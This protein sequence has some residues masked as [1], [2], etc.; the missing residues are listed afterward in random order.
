MER[1]EEKIVRIEKIAE[2]EILKQ[3]FDSKKQE[4]DELSDKLMRLNAEFDNY[5]KRVANEK[6]DLMDYA[7]KDI[8]RALLPIVD[9]FEKAMDQRNGDKDEFYNGIK[10]IFASLM[11]MLKKNGLK[12]MDAAGSAFDPHFHEAIAVVEKSDVEENI[13]IEETHAGYLL[14]DKVLRPAMVVISKKK[15]DNKL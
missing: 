6:K 4:V 8:L 14:H 15:L 12:K 10:M 2:L 9:S 13:V 1:E 7:H 3:S 11:D 5:K